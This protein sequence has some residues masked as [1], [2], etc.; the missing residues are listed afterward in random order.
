MVLCPLVVDTLL[1]YPRHP[2]PFIQMIN[3]HGAVSPCG[4]YVASCGFTP[5]VK[6]WQVQFSKTGD[7][8]GVARAFELKGHSAGEE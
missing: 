1:H 2:F 8:I 3:S 5:D 6:V 4:R 7:F